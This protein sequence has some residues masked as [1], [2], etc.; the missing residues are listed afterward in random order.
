MT[1]RFPNTLHKEWIKE[2]DASLKNFKKQLIGE[3]KDRTDVKASLKQFF[4]GVH[5]RISSSARAR[6]TNRRARGGRC[7]NFST[8][9]S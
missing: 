1:W 9:R 7:P 8:R 4:E 3:A 6:T 2:Y 5:V